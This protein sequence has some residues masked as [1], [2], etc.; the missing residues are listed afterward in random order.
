MRGRGGE[1]GRQE[2]LVHVVVRVGLHL[3]QHA[4]P[5]RRGRRGARRGHDGDR[6]KSCRADEQASDVGPGD[7]VA[8]L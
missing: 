8:Q 7:P 1:D 4:T 2:G 6:Y 5:R 3:V